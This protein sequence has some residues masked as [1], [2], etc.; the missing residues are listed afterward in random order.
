MILSVVLSILSVSF[1]FF[2]GHTYHIPF[3]EYGLFAIVFIAHFIIKKVVKN[4]SFVRYFRSAVWT[5]G[6]VTLVE[7][8]G[9]TA[10][11][12]FYLMYFLLFAVALLVS[13]Y[14]SATIGISYCMYAFFFSEITQTAELI[15]PLLGLLAITPFAVYLGIEKKENI[16][17]KEEVETDKEKARSQQ[18]HISTLHQQITILISLVLD[19]PVKRLH[20]LITNKI[21]DDQSGIVLKEVT[22]VK[23]LLNDFNRSNE[24]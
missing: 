21:I 20:D 8:T 24:L 13:T 4:A 7:S 23:K 12:Y 15:L 17:L 22:E 2:A 10:S 19:G 1:G 18:K 11:S 6:I 3:L 9:G 14:E 5:I 16:T